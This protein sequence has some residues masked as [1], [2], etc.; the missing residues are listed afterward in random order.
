MRSGGLASAFG[1]NL[2]V[3]DIYATQKVFGRGRKF[4]RIDLAVKEGVTLA[5]CR[6]ALERRLGPAFDVRPPAA[7]GQQFE[8][9]MQGYSASLNVSSAFALFIGLF[10]IY[11]SFSIAVT[12]RRTEIGILRALGATRRQIGKLFLGESGVLGLLGSALG[13]GLGMLLAEGLVRYIG[14]VLQGAFGVAERGLE[15]IWSPM[16]L[17]AALGL[18]TLTSLL[19]AFL[20]ARA[21]AAVDPVQALQ[22]GKGQVLSAGENRRRRAAAAILLSGS[23]V[24]LL[25]GSSRFFFYGGYALLLTATL[26]LTPTLSLWLAGFLRPLLKRLRPIEGA[27]AADS[28]IQAPRR[29]SAT[30]SAL[31][32]CL[33][34]LI[35]LAGTS[36]ASYNSIEEWLSTTLNPD[37]FVS[38]SENLVS[39]SYR[40]PESMR[41]DL[42]Q[43]EGIQE[44]QPVRNSSQYTNHLPEHAGAVDLGRY[45]PGGE[46]YSR[47]P[48]HSGQRHGNESPGQPRQGGDRIGEPGAAEEPRDGKR[49]GA[50]H[51]IRHIA[52]AGRGHRPRFLQPAGGDLS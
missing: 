37:L 22:K 45:R 46:P 5:Q 28:L 17:L 3:M 48:D 12:Q 16:L 1:G 52:A 44:V 2:A 7:R 41:A 42:E 47:A 19:A 34:M 23:V 35:G 13:I 18:G 33:A 40:F 9:M 11:N 49:A 26:L 4:D 10:I 24:C 8:S 20:P 6:S 21:A 39:R 25:L 51:R 38:A 30:V 43:L 36:R 32:L 31:M 50:A 14:Q 15:L 29:T 27:L